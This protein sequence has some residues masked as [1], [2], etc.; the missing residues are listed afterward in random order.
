MTLVNPSN[1]YSSSSKAGKVQFDYL[2]DYILSANPNPILRCIN[3]NKLAKTLTLIIDFS[4]QN[5]FR[6]KHTKKLGH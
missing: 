3:V 1:I 5:R 2:P 6:H 4:L